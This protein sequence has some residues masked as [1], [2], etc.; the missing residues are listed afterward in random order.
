MDMTP[1]A[2]F[3]EILQGEGPESSSPGMVHLPLDIKEILPYLPSQG[4]GSVLEIL[5][6]V[7]STNTYLLT[8]PWEQSPHGMVVAAESQTAGKGRHGRRW[9]AP[10]YR[11]LSFSLVLRP[12]NNPGGLVTLTAACVSVKILRGLS[13]PAGIKWPN[14]V[15]EINSGLKLGGILCEARQE[16]DASLRLVLGIGLNVN[17]DKE[18]LPEEIRDQATSLQIL[19]GHPI[20]RNALLVSLLQSF[21]AAWIVLEQ[22]GGE[23]LIREARPLCTTLGCNLRLESHGRAIE[24]MAIDL[25]SKGRLVLRLPSGVHRV[26]EIGEILKTRRVD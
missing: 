2:S 14:D 11:N 1:Y 12:T 6:E 5:K 17:Q 8:L 21:A 10:P 16:T 22:D 25:D 19:L 18:D 20:N 24:G 26:V 7:S 15:I 23:S 9:L 4:I 3:P 13:I